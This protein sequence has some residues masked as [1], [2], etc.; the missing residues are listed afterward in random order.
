MS[1]IPQSYVVQATLLSEAEIASHFQELHPDWVVA[2]QASI[3]RPFELPDF[4][5][6]L[7]LVNAIGEVAEAENHHPELLMKGDRFVTI[8]FTTHD[9]GGITINDLMMAQRTDQ[10]AKRIPGT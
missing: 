7:A 4:K 8:T 9:A 10:Q 6:A 2:G 3:S 5:A 1:P